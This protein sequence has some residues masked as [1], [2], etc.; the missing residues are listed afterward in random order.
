MFLLFLLIF[1]LIAYYLTLINIDQK[2]HNYS[3]NGPEYN[4]TMSITVHYTKILLHLL[5]LDK[6]NLICVK[7]YE[8]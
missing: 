3:R 5:D 1:Y 7:I 4:I 2:G 6:H 8:P